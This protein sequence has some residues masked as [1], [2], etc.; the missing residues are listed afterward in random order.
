MDLITKESIARAVKVE[1]FTLAGDHTVHLR[2]LSGRG[3]D[4]WNQIARDAAA[5]GTGGDVERIC[6]SLLV[7]CI[8]TPDGGRVYGNDEASLLAESADSHLIQE[9]FDHA[10]ALNQMGKEGHDAAKKDLPESGDSGSPS[11]AISE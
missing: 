5:G 2:V 7:R 9:M 1:K 8:C 6:C 10:F 3:R 4:E 11:P